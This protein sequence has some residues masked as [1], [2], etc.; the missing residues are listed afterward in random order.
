[1]CCVGNDDDLRSGHARGGWSVRRRQEGRR[2]RRPHHRLGRDRARTARG[3]RQARLR[4]HRRSGVRR[5]GRR[6]ERRAHRDVRRRRRSPTGAPSRSSPPMRACASCWA[7]RA[8]AS[9]PRWSIR[10]A[11]PAWCRAS[12]RASTSPSAPASTSRPSSTTISKGA[13]QSW[14][15][16]NRYK[17]MNAGQV[18]LRLRGRLDAQGPVDLPRRG[19]PQRRP[20]AGHRAGRSVLRRGAEDGR[21]ALGHVEPDRAARPIEPLSVRFRP[22]GHLPRSARRRH[23]L[24]QAGRASSGF[25]CVIMICRALSSGSR[26]LRISQL[27]WPLIRPAWP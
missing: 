21:P 3:S 1:M 5:P 18:R 16:E 13:A 10:S 4:L 6:R 26:A 19:A 14:Q 15:M 8:R 12:P 22:P 11:S 24:H 23:A 2:L 7:R 27:R 17:T 25:M 9:S 20:S